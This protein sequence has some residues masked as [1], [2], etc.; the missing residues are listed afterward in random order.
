MR[1]IFLLL[2][3]FLSLA[4]L[5]AIGYADDPKLPVYPDSP[6]S[7]WTVEQQAKGLGVD[8]EKEFPEKYV[9][10]VYFHR[11]PS[12]DHCQSMARNAYA[13]LKESF[14]KEVQERKVNIK[15]IN[16]EAKENRPVIETLGIKKPTIILFETSPE[17]VRIQKASR[18]WD[19]ADNTEEFKKYIRKE[20]EEFLKSDGKSR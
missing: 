12:C 17:G 16:F 13:V 8:L 11:L 15:Y 18:I 9:T 3:V 19:L 6:P 1:R 4:H 20:L 5:S 10:L 14:G 2:V 7:Y